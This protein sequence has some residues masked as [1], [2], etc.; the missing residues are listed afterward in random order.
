MKKNTKKAVI[1]VAAIL[2]VILVITG[3]L[4]VA[5]INNYIHLTQFGATTSRQMM[6]YGIKT[7]NNEIVLID[8]G[9]Q[10]DASQLEEY[11]MKNGG[12]VHAWFITHLHTDHAGAFEVISQNPKIKIE[13]IY[14]SINSKEWHIENDSTRA[15]DIENF[16]EVMENEELQQ[17]VIEPQVGDEIKIDNIT[18]EILGVKNPEI[19][20][21]ATNNSSMVIKIKVNHKKIL[22]LGDTGIESSEKLIREQGENL[23]ADIVQV[24]HHGQNGATEELYKIIKPKICLWP[25]PDW[26]WRND[27][28][29]T[30]DSGPWK[31]KE[32][33]KWMEQINVKQHYIEKDGTHEIKIF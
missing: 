12:T 25:T 21:N 20:T 32:T 18:A 31:T 14:M 27:S 2:A 11:I 23:K 19:T 13:K 4:Y 10:E 29:G 8:G 7:K 9:T 24:A 28:N 1:I 22:F 5:R 15:E 26:L 33:R 3:I 17:K 6:A 30:E 16:F